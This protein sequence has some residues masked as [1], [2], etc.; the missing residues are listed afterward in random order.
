MV[1]DLEGALR[2]R[3]HTAT[4]NLQKQRRS[5]AHDLLILSPTWWSMGDGKLT[6]DND[7]EGVTKEIPA[8]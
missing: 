1:R 2:A 6:L 7:L 3:T 4:A 8:S 5:Q